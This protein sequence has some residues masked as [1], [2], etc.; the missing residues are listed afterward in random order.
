MMP[1]ESVDLDQFVRI[2]KEV[3]KDTK[4]CE[5]EEFISE[6]VDMFYRIV[7]KISINVNKEESTTIMFEDLT[8]Y[9]ITHE[10]AFDAELGTIGA[11]NATNAS[12]FSMEYKESTIKDPTTHNNYIEKIHYFPQIDKVI[13]YEINNMNMRIYNGL[14]MK[15]EI[16]VKC[17]G[18]ILAVEFISDKNS[19]CVSL[20][21]RSFQ[22]FD[23][24]SIMEK[25]NKHKFKRFPLPST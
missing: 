13:L 20:S 11:L 14:T 24:N 4:L 15:N 22:F 9:L 25:K 21:D 2:M 10:I 23:A 16:D 17:P 3:L 8:N 7:K 5:R 19:I 1:A 12:S 18:N 6:L